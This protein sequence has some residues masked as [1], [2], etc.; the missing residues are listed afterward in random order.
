MHCLQLSRQEC[1]L[2]WIGRSSASGPRRASPDACAR[3][4]IARAATSASVP[5]ETVDSSIINSFI[6]AVSGIVSVGENA[7]DVLNE[8]NT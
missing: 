1:R 3:I 2:D 6:L 8:R 5:S 4:F 7:V